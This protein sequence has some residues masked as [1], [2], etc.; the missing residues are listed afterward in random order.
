MRFW[1]TVSVVL[2]FAGLAFCSSRLV[3]EYVSAQN[4]PDHVPLPILSQ[5]TVEVPKK[6]ET[7]HGRVHV[8]AKANLRNGVAPMQLLWFCQVSQQFR[9]KDGSYSYEVIW[10]DD[11]DHQKFTSHKG[12]TIHPTFDEMITL[13]PGEYLVTVGVKKVSTPNKD[14]KSELKVIASTYF[15]AIVKE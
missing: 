4:A 6:L 1:K 8:H 7:F 10:E 15:R 12:E 13:P 3:V 2:V 9:Q 5:Y 14:G 11:Y